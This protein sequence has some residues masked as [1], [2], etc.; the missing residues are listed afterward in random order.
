VDPTLLAAGAN[1][2]S[3]LSSVTQSPASS[4]RAETATYNP[5]D[6][7][8]GFNVNFAPLG[9][10]S[11]A[12]SPIAGVSLPAIGGVSGSTVAIGLLAV[13]AVVL[14]ARRRKG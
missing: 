7:G 5:F 6:A 11:G 1:A 8:G 3:R 2:L 10:A 13:A 14:I 12:S 4:S 9:S